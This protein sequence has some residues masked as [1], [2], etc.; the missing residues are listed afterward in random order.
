MWI[1]SERLLSISQRLAVISLLNLARPGHSI[2]ASRIRSIA[3]PVGVYLGGPVKPGRI[4]VGRED[5]LGG[6][7]WVDVGSPRTEWED[8]RNS[9]VPIIPASFFTG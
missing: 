8:R 9:S 1:E 4:L 6:R 5:D 3:N 2:G 7:G